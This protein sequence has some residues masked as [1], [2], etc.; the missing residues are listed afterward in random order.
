MQIVGSCS[1]CL[2]Q[3]VGSCSWCLMQIVGS[4]S[5]C[6]MQIVGSCSWC[7]VQIVGSCMI[8]RMQTPMPPMP[9]TPPVS[10]LAYVSL[11]FKS[12]SLVH[13]THCPDH[14]CNLLSIS[15]WACACLCLLVWDVCECVNWW[16]G[17]FSYRQQIAEQQHKCSTPSGSFVTRV[18]VNC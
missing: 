9:P 11:L 2:V 15:W 3:I 13:P 8:K 4:C 10:S 18:F 1:W 16:N 12:A 14:R 5:W 17:T 7:L 6:L